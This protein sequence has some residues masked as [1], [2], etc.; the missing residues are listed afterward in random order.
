MKI[1]TAMYEG[2]LRA[3][4]VPQWATLLGV[5]NKFLYNRKHR[6]LSDQEAIQGVYMPLEKKVLPSDEEIDKFYQAFNFND[7]IYVWRK[8][9]GL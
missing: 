7:Q 3:L 2:R 5:S 8:H 6:N 9:N 1:I 4:T